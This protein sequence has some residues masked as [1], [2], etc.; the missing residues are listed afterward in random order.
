MCRKPLPPAVPLW[1]ARLEMQVLRVYGVLT[2]RPRRLQGMDVRLMAQRTTVSI[3]R[4]R[5][6]LSWSPRTSIDDGMAVC[7]TWLRREGHLPADDGVIEMP[8][9][10]KVAG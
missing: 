9:A 7:E 8:E 2:Q 5:E 6:V 3:E 1:R 10:R 4:A